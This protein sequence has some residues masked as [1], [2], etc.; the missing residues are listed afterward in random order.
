M[1][2]KKTK[3]RYDEY[4]NMRTWKMTPISNATKDA[5]AA[6]LYDWALNDENA[7]KLSQFYTERGISYND[8][9]RWLTQHERLKQAHDAAKI[10]IGNRREIGALKNKLN[11][12]VV[13]PSMPKYDKDWKDLAEWRASM[14]AEAQSD[15]NNTVKVVIENFNEKEES[16]P[17]PSKRIVKK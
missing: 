8:F 11:A 10:L 17:Q 6:E 7:F 12:G 5:L 13:V 9:S 3:F 16:K 2:E 15:G 1:D 4:S 14:K